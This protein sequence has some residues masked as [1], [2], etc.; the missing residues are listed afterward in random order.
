MSGFIRWWASNK[1]A[2]NLLMIALI[3]AGIVAYLRM[4]RELEPYVEFPGAA[5]TVVWRGASPQD[6]EEQLTVRMEEAVSTVE[7][8]K[9]LSSSSYEGVAR[10]VVVG[11]EDLDRPRFTSSAAAMKSCASLFQAT[12]RSANKS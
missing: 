11:N 2:A 9:E 10:L 5:I 7:G 8:I 1:V 6:V 3:I 4:E 12:T